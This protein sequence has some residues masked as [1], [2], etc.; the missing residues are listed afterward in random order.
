MN[1]NFELA[2]E[3]RDAYKSNKGIGRSGIKLPSDASIKFEKAENEEAII[4][5]V[6][7]KSIVANMQ[8]NEAAFEGW[9]LAITHWLPQYTK[10]YLNWTSACKEIGNKS[11]RH[12]Q[13][14]LYRAIMF[15]NLFTWF[16]LQDR[17][18]AI[19]SSKLFEN[20]IYRDSLYVN[21]PSSVPNQSRKMDFN[22]RGLFKDFHSASEDS[23]EIQI[24]KQEVIQQQHGMRFDFMNRQLPVGLFAG[25]NITKPASIFTGGK[26]A[27]DIFGIKD[28][29]LFIFE[30]KKAGVKSV[31]ILSELFFYSCFFH[32]F[33]KNNFKYSN[34]KY[35]NNLWANFAEN[36][37]YYNGVLESINAYF[38]TTDLHPLL[39]KNSDGISVLDILNAS[40][41]KR[42]FNIEFAHLP[43]RC[44]ECK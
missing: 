42:N 13:R 27:I 34:Q 11:N 2:K 29:K 6:T 33:I 39:D 9:A 35:D 4:I 3:L 40:C 22:N 8:T 10:I 32:D 23:L 12:F 24:L 43:L 25:E 14:F 15:D 20:N 37:S 36:G 26:S 5:N 28:N 31:G 18:L 17:E 1:I 7:R 41:V 30:L 44:F 19:S 16:E 38:L 21:G